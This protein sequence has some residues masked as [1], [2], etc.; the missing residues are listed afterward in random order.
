MTNTLPQIG[1]IA[2]LQVNST[3]VGYLKGVT[4][5]PTAKVVKEYASANTG[6]DLAAVMYSGNKEFKIDADIMYVDETYVTLFL[7]NSNSITIVFGPV[8][9][10]VGNPKETYNNCV[11][12]SA[13]IDHKQDGIVGHK[14]NFEAQSL[15]V[16]TW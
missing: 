3:T 4:T 7:S 1:R 12:A 6:G 15:T 8:G 11:M 2:L 9:T 14:L 16:G 13:E 10:S 5:K